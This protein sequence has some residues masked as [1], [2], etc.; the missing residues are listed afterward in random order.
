MSGTAQ[1]AFPFYELISFLSGERRIVF[2]F[3]HGGA[4]PCCVVLVGLL[5]L[6]LL[7]EQIV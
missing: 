6:L 4:P 7:L 1:S 5:V 2:V 3:E